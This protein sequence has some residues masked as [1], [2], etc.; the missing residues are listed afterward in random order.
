MAHEVFIS[1]SQADCDA[2]Q[3]VCAE[4]ER[5]GFTCWIAPR[6]VPHGGAY[7]AEIVQA[8][9]NCRVLVLLLSQHTTQSRH[10]ANEIHLALE[11]GRSVLPLR[12]GPVSL[13][14][15]LEYQLG[16]VQWIDAYPPPLASHLDSVVA[17]IRADLALPPKAFAGAAPKRSRLPYIALSMT[18]IAACG[19]TIGVWAS[20]PAAPPIPDIK[21]PPATSPIAAV[22]L[23]PELLAL[24]AGPILQELLTGYPDPVEGRINH[25]AIA[26]EVCARRPGDEAFIPLSN[27]DSMRS[28]VDL[29]L[30]ALRPETNGFLYVIQ[31]DSHGQAA[32]LFPKYAAHEVSSGENPVAA[33]KIVEIPPADSGTSL[34]LDTQTGTEQ[35]YVAFS[36]SRWTRLEKLLERPS[37]STSSGPAPQPANAAG[38]RSL[39]LRGVGGTA[40]TSGTERT[41][42]RRQDG[43]E[44]PL[45]V[46]SESKTSVGGFLVIGRQFR[47]IP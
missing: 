16:R 5:G 43:R 47:H 29:Y 22:S 18:V 45:P 20:R 46:P 39:V 21:S 30:I 40:K 9:T 6:D 38:S 17:R 10:V 11:R 26:A 31:V 24:P 12:L 27:G 41:I 33:A 15:P 34:F 8:I 3:L 36:A 32:V 44:F 37:A 4:L 42:M 28:L 19:V 14:G 2:A 35:I 13:A 1:Y 23:A 7:D 25:P